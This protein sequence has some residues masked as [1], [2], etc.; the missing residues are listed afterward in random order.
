MALRGLVEIPVTRAATATLVL[1][2][3]GFMAWASADAA[4]P[5]AGHPGTDKGGAEVSEPLFAFLLALSNGDSLGVWTGRDI[6]A[7]AADRGHRSKFP[8]DQIASL[9]RRRPLATEPDRWPDGDLT[10]M[11]EL[12]PATSGHRCPYD[13]GLEQNGF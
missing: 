13:I 6:I 12:E 1:V 3:S 8:L 4:D 5:Y 2:L 7:F 11:W 10:A 9:R